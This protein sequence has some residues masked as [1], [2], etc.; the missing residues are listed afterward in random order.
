MKLPTPANNN[1]TSYPT[2]LIT[3]A[4]GFVGRHLCQ[5][6][7]RDECVIH[8][9]VRREDP[10]LRLLGIKLWLGDLWDTETLK[11]AAANV[12]VVI[13]CAGNPNFGNGSQ[14]YH[15]NV[16]MTAHL[17]EVI[18][19]AAKNIQR[20]L[21]VSTIGAVDRLKKDLCSDPLNENSLPAPSSDYGRSKLQAEEVVMASGLPFTIVRP[22]MVVGSDMRFNSHFSVFSRLPLSHSIVSRIA[23]PGCFSVVHVDDLADALTVVATHPD[24]IGQTF[25]CAGDAISLAD[26]FN[27]SCPD[28]LRLPIKWAM[29]IARPTVPWFPFSLKAMLLPALTASDHRLRQLGWQPRYSARSALLD[30]IFREKARINPEID[31]G[32]QTVITGAASGLGRA[33]VQRLAPIRQRLLIIDHDRDNL[34]S[35]ASQYPNCLPLVIDLSVESELESLVNSKNWNAFPVSELFACAGIGLR[36]TMQELSLQSHKKMFSVNVLS[37]LVL[38]H[39]AINGMQHRQ[40]GRI[41]LISSSSAFQPLPYMATY[42]ATNSALLSMGEAWSQEIADQ[43]IHIMIVCP[44]GMQTNFQKSAGVKEIEGEKLMSPSDVAEEI[45]RGLNARRTTLIVSFRSLVMAF[46]ARI[47]PRRVSTRLWKKLM[48]KMR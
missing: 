44:G 30:V 42:A 31:P 36:G 18:R 4:S 46:L 21:F 39:A 24:A 41:V 20:F 22:A 8:A 38:T 48:E 34:L 37:R 13:H 32:G 14:Y 45:M 12:N 1:S 33:L 6:L 17:I 3:G 47:L 9:I 27:L 2:Y 43:G 7:S 35:V 19:S 40:F 23:W 15:S 29:T 5:R 25:F 16:D 11:L 28:T 10:Y 26:C